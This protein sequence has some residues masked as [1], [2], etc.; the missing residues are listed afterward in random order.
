[1]L[2]VF[3]NN[4][5]A[6][7]TSATK[8]PSPKKNS[9][10]DDNSDTHLHELHKILTNEWKIN[11]P[12]ARTILRQ[13][14]K[15]PTSKKKVFISVDPFTA[16]DKLATFKKGT[17]NMRKMSKYEQMH[18][19]QNALQSRIMVHK[20]NDDHSIVYISQIKA[21]R[22][23]MEF[24]NR[25]I[26]SLSKMVT[27]KTQNRSADSFDSFIDLKPSVLVLLSDTFYKEKKLN[28]T[29][30]DKI[31]ESNKLGE[32]VVTSTELKLLRKSKRDILVDK[33]FQTETNKIVEDFPD[34]LREN[35]TDF[36]FLLG[37]SSRP[38]VKQLLNS[39]R[40]IHQLSLKYEQQMYHLFRLSVLS[41][42]LIER[43]YSP[44]CLL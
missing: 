17:A 42:I 13:K 11:N 2:S 39:F 34:V 7:E 10:F 28:R 37:F 21:I 41:R 18:K 20:Y 23:L 38:T 22:Q 5:N 4:R 8:N 25:Q 40:N 33:V 43:T 14:Q 44:K 32:Q 29:V 26:E 1:M 31:L 35:E 15:T 12:D 27:L 30:D 9:L 24:L 16:E 3:Y 36:Y 19:L 6:S